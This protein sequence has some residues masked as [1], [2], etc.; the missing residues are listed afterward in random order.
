MVAIEFVR[1][2]IDDF[3]CITKASLE[4]HLDKLK[5]VLTRLRDAGLCINTRKSF[6]CT[7]EMEY[8]GYILMHTGLKPQPKKVQVIL[9]ITLPKQV[10]D[11]CKFLGMFQYY[12]DLWARCSEMLAPLTSLV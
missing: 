5:M 11:L 3:L 6:F 12:R 10:K 9:A 8:L 4:D 2:Y 1:A 7:I